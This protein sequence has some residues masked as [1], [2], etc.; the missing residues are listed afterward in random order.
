MRPLIQVA[1]DLIDGKQAL[2]MAEIVAPYVDIIEVGTPLLKAEGIKIIG[3]LKKK[4]PD[5]LLLAD[6]KTMDVGALEAKLVFDVEADIMTV[7][8]AAAIETIAAAIN[9][10]ERQNKK[11]MVDFIG[12]EDKI[13][14]AK[15]IISLKPYYFNLHTA[16]DIQKSKGKSFEEVEVF[17]KTFSIPLAIAG[18][19]VPEDIAALMPFNPAILI[20][21][22]FITKATDPKRAVLEINKEVDNVLS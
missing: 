4:H 2:T 17:S 13:S 5:K 20:F 10:A 7:C 6:T 3:T 18:G 9:E 11:I 22:G 16:I 21:G 12:I 1:L 14:R 8:A 19:L 15:Q